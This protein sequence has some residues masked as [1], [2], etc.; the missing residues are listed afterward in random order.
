MKSSRYYQS[1]LQVIGMG[2][3]VLLFLSGVFVGKGETLI[4]ICFLIL[5][6]ANK[7]LVSDLMYRRH[8]ALLRESKEMEI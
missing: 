2:G 3:E 5:K 7:Y 6:M 8:Q 1:V 4:A